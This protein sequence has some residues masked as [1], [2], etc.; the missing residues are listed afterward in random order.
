MPEREDKTVGRAVM[1]PGISAGINSLSLKLSPALS[2]VP[3][4]SVKYVPTDSVQVR[5]LRPAQE[6]LREKMNT[7]T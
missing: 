1:K 7:L 3:L 4:Q 5:F 6:L 2:A